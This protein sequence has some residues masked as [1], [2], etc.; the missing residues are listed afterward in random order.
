MPALHAGIG[1]QG[2][3][4]YGRTCVCALRRQRFDKLRPT[5]Y[6][7][8]VSELYLKEF[9]SCPTGF[10]YFDRKV[11]RSKWPTEQVNIRTG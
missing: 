11:L 3:V 4:S 2:C 8:P 7:L 10:T 1:S 5:P 6:M 9:R